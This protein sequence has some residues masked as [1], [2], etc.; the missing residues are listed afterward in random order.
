[1][2]KRFIKQQLR[3]LENLWSKYSCDCL[4]FEIK[5]WQDKLAEIKNEA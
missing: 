5:D 4:Y 1:M 2:S 3:E